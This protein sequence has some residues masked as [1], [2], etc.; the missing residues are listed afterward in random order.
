M[1]SLRFARHVHGDVALDICWSCHAMWFDQ[2]ESAQLTPGA[3]LALFRQIHEHH[4]HPPR[5]LGDALRCPRCTVVLVPTHDIQKNTRLHY[6][7]CPENHGRLTTFMQFLREK[8]FVRPLS[9]PEIERLRAS[10]SQVRCSSCGAAVNIAHDA[11]CQYCRAPLAMLDAEAVDRALAT[12][13]TAERNR[14]HP[15]PARADE[16]FDA[17]L[18]AY[19][20]SP[21]VGTSGWTRDVMIPGTTSELVDLMVEGL[22]L[23]F[24]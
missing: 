15:P 9:P 23:L 3:V 16:T 13:S 21:R 17:L 22:R 4:A 8:A 19:K 24:R 6:L 14:S 5:P 20:T 12:L 10:V 2:Y 1:E 7:R 11:I 18:A